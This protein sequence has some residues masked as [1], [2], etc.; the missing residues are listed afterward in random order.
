MIN[1]I[2]DEKLTASVHNDDVGVHGSSGSVE[3]GR[4]TP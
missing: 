1:R 2:K 4:P 3:R